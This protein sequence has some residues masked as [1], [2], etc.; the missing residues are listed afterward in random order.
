MQLA[1]VALD[2]KV[3]DR[4]VPDPGLFAK[5]AGFS[6]GRTSAIGKLNGSQVSPPWVGSGLRPAGVNFRHHCR[7]DSAPRQANERLG[8]K[9]AGACRPSPPDGGYGAVVR[10]R[11]SPR[12][13]RLRRKRSATPS[14]INKTG[15]MT[16]NMPAGMRPKYLATPSDPMTMSAMGKILTMGSE[17]R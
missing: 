9:T 7:A 10:P 5:Q 13:P 16:W 4:A 14:A 3:Q 2:A 11:Q 1:S 12:Q 17:L 6:S 8:T 15:P